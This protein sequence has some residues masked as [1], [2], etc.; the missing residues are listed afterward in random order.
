MH[1]ST[2]LIVH[3]VNLLVHNVT[4]RWIPINGNLHTDIISGLF[5][6]LYQAWIELQNEEPTKQKQIIDIMLEGILTQI[7]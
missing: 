2:I 7:L 3:N 4:V 5:H 1:Y 6:A